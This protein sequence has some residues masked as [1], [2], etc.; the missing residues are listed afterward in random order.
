MS[1][2]KQYVPNLNEE[3]TSSNTAS[4]DGVSFEQFVNR[5]DE[6]TDLV[7]L[8]KNIAETST[9]ASMEAITHIN[10]GVHKALYLL[11]SKHDWSMEAGT[12]LDEILKADTSLMKGLKS[13]TDSI[14]TKLKDFLY[15][16]GLTVTSK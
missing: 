5:F 1:F 14:W 3:H 8:Q 15:K 4:I 16:I 10:S 13:K 7:Q 12:P 6:F 11:G 9:Y 2:L